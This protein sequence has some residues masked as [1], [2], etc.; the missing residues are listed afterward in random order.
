MEI[1]MDEYKKKILEN[2]GID[3]DEVLERFMGNTGLMDK[4]FSKFLN[5]MNYTKLNTAILCGDA[6][7]A[8]LAAHTLKGLCGDLYF[9]DLGKIVCKQTYLLKGGDMESATAIMPQ[10]AQEYEKLSAAFKDC[11]PLAV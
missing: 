11:L 3:M 8:F 9:K 4:F 10:V 5:D 6:S 7:G 2:A 1:V